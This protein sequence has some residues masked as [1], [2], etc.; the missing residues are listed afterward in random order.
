MTWFSQ[1]PVATSG[2]AF[3]S[4]QVGRKTVDFH[5]ALP[6]FGDTDS[7]QTVEIHLSPVGAAA[8]PSTDEHLRSLVR[9]VLSALEILHQS[10]LVHRDVRMAN[11]IN[12]RSQWILIDFELAGRA[13]EP[14]WFVSLPPAKAR[15]GRST[16][17]SG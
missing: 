1:T 2:F 11:V 9:D 8:D 13:D 17:P 4:K 6:Q 16:I 5:Q 15:S 3:A 14:V 12:F 7:Q 10:G